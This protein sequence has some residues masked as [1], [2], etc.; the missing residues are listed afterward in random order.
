[1]A[2]EDYVKKD[3]QLIH[4]EIFLEQT[5]EAINS[6]NSLMKKCENI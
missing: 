3:T 1:M 4:P 6:I 5:V 2:L